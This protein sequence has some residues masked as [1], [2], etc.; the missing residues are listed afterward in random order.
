MVEA[1]GSKLLPRR[2]ETTLQLPLIDSGG[3][4]NL[5][6]RNTR[7]EGRRSKSKDITTTVT[8]GPAGVAILREQTNEN[9]NY[10]S[11]RS[12]RNTN[13]NAYNIISAFV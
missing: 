9:R 8:L 1:G 6:T 7:R 4:W 10:A 11:V 2:G 5:G 12:K 13:T 3:M